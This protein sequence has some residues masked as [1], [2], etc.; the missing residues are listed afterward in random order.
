MSPMVNREMHKA[1]SCLP[2][3]YFRRKDNGCWKGDACDHCHLCTFPEMMKRRNRLN[4][5]NR[6][7][8]K[9]RNR[10]EQRQESKLEGFGTGNMFNASRGESKVMFWL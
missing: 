10:E 1:G 3:L 5:L 2:C 4:L 9:Q 7:E 6:K 8:R